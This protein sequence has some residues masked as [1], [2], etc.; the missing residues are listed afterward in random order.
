M[1]EC[2]KCGLTLPLS[3]F[4][5][6]SRAN[7]L[8]HNVCKTCSRVYQATYYQS[9]SDRYKAHRRVN[10]PRYRRER[11]RLLLEYLKD[12]QCVDC[13]ERDPVVLDFDHVRGVK[14][15]DVG[16]M[17][18]RY[19]WARILDELKKCQIRCANCHRRKT[20]RDFKWFK[21]NFGA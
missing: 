18:G 17:L 14:T 1:K 6:R 3:A 21:G 5:F 2:S 19:A 20:A 4:A 13:G 15:G 10:Q 9:N 8:R 16:R 11:R 12:K 7:D